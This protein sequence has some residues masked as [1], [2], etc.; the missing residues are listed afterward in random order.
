MV[1]EAVT[2]RTASPVICITLS[3]VQ[4]VQKM[5]A[6]ANIPAA[7]ALCGRSCLGRRYKR[8]GHPGHNTVYYI[9]TSRRPQGT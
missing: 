9:S 7:E 4:K 8:L 2:H 1:G 5:W 6:S 3:V